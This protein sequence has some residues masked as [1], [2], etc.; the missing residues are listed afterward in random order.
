MAI[1]HESVIKAEAVRILGAYEADRGGKVPWSERW[2][3]G[4][5]ARHVAGTHH[6]VAQVI[7]GRPTAD[8]GLFGSLASPAKD[9]PGFPDWFAAGSTALCAQ[10]R[11][12]SAS[13]GCWSWYG[14]GRSVGFWRRRMAHETLVHR[15]DAEAGA[16]TPGPAMDPSVAA[17]GVDE[18]LDVFVKATREVHNAPSGP[19]VQLTCTDAERTWYLDLAEP[20]GRALR[21]E[22]VIVS[23]SVLG[24]AEGLLLTLWRRLDPVAA[25][26]HVEGDHELLTRWGELIPPM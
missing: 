1:D 15:W 2:T 14:D 11:A 17:D 16:G 25:G 5:V 22:P 23:T 3:V 4:T 7:A 21:S 12:T 18:F 26:V 24:P 6:V 8:F 10:L 19:S 20:G 13:E 9:D